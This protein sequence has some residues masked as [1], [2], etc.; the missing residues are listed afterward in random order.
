MDEID[1][2]TSEFEKTS[3]DEKNEYELLMEAVNA[4]FAQAVA[5]GLMKRAKGRYERM[6][7]GIE[8]DRYGQ[9]E[10]LINRYLQMNVEKEPKKSYYDMKTIDKAVL[11]ILRKEESQ[12]VQIVEDEVREMSEKIKKVRIQ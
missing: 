7:M 12:V 11:R 10:M 1:N 3:I 9:L 4:T 5:G 8:L 6:M 2:L